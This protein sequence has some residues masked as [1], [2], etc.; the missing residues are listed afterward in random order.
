M[1]R[2]FLSSQSSVAFATSLVLCGVVLTVSGCAG[3]TPTSSPT[4]DTMSTHS[5]EAEPA[6][7]LTPGHQVFLNNCMGC[8]ANSENP[9]GPNAVILRSSKTDTLRHFEA[10]V[11]NPDNGKMPP[12]PIERLS[13]AEL[14]ELYIYIHNRIEEQR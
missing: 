6:K 12:F 5:V 1:F 8:H 3:R 14:G 9:P 13:N 4:Q 11:R 7:E 2:R 10:F